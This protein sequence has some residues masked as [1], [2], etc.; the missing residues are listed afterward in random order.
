MKTRECKKCNTEKP[1]EAFPISDSTKGYRRHMCASCYSEWKG[2]HYNKNYDEIRA[3]QNARSKAAYDINVESKRKKNSAWQTLYREKFR[4]LVYEAYGNRCACCGETTYDFLTIDHKNNDG[5]I[6]RKKK[7]H[8]TDT[9]SFHRWLVRN[10][11][12]DSFQLLCMN[13]NFGKARNGGVCPH[14]QS[15]STISKESTAK[16]LEVRGVLLRMKDHDIVRSTG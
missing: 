4:Q 12:P 11:F 14:E 2:H 16:R 3:K 7:L 13:C 1:I 6:A 10:N 8:P 15:S 5:W 9:A